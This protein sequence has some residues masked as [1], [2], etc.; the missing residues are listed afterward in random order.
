MTRHHH[1]PAPIRF[2]KLIHRTCQVSISFKFVGRDIT[3]IG[4]EYSL[5]MPK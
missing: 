2:F 5:D 3:L 4:L 1:S